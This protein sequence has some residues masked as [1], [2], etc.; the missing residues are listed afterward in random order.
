[1]K[2]LMLHAGLLLIMVSAAAQTSRRQASQVNTETEHRRS[3]VST[4]RRSSASTNA[5]RNNAAVSQSRSAQGQVNTHN[6]NARDIDR[7]Q[8]T[9]TMVRVEGQER[10]SQV[11][12]SQRHSNVKVETRHQDRRTVYSTPRNYVRVEKR[13]HYPSHSYKKVYVRQ[14][15]RVNIVWDVH[16]HREYR[17]IYPYIRTWNISYGSHIHTVS[18]YDAPRYVGDVKRVFGYVTEVHYDLYADE[19]HLYLN[20]RFPFQDF[21][22]IVPGYVA[23]QMSHRPE[24]FFYGE[25]ISTTGFIS[26]FNNRPEMV[27]KRNYQMEIYR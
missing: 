23:R 19:Y 25:Y 16:M 14:P 24:R 6:H 8:K 20:D 11:R 27:V 15:A 10:Q 3:N 9:N 2:R 4:E 22:V 17:H 7:P 1:M 13:H 21:T 18:A 12:N 5:Q 26:E